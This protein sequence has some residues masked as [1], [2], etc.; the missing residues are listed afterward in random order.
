VDVPHVMAGVPDGL[1]V[2]LLHE[3]HF[4]V[5][6]LPFK[7]FSDVLDLLFGRFQHSWLPRWVISPRLQ[8]VCESL[9]NR[10]CRGAP[11]IRRGNAGCPHRKRLGRFQLDVSPVPTRPVPPSEPPSFTLRGVG[12]RGGNRS[13]RAFASTALQA[14]PPVSSKVRETTGDALEICKHALAPF[15][16]QAG[17]CSGKEMIINHGAR[18]PSGL[19]QTTGTLPIQSAPTHPSIPSHRSSALGRGR[20]VLGRGDRPRGATAEGRGAGASTWSA[21]FFQ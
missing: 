2:D 20:P 1:G 21:V 7:V 12:E 10:R 3:G 8:R 14:E 17:N 18:S 4:E 16:V 9:N 6:S 13:R 11:K 19:Y 5:R 15:L